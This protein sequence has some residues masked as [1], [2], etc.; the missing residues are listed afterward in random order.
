MKVLVADKLAEEGL[1]FL[2]GSG[3]NF[4]VKVGLKE[5]ELAAEVAGGG[6]EALIVRSGAKVTAKV[7]ENPGALRAIARAG[8]GVDNIDLEAATNKGILVLNTAEAS[9][10][11]TAEHA[12][13][14]LMSLARK[15]PQAHAH[16]RGGGWK[17]ND[18]QGTQLAGKTAGVVGLGRIG[19]TVAS[20]LLALEMTV[21]GFDPYFAG[22]TALDGKVKLVR[23]FDEFL[24]Q[25]DVITFHVPGGEGTKHLLSRER[26]F[27]VA[28]KS[29][30]VINDA[31]GEV[32]D[33]FALAEALKEKRIA[34]AALDV[35][36]SEPPQK[37]HP[38]FGLENVVLTPHLGASTDEAQTAVS[39]EACKA[40]VAYLS[41]GEI[42]GAVNA[43]GL[44]LDLPADERPFADLAARM[45]TLLSG[46]TE[47]AI[48]SI[49][50]RAS[51]AKAPKL[52]QTMMRLA[53]V[54]LLRPHVEAGINVINAEVI[55][56]GRG[57]DLVTVH[58]PNP[59]AG[60]V[61]DIVSIRAELQSGGTHRILGTV[62]ADG[63]PRVVRIDNFAM[64]MVPEGQMVLIV[65]KD[66][67][68]V[69]GVVGTSF[70][71]AGVNIADMVISRDFAADGSATAVMVLKVD[72]APPESLVN[73]L[74]ARPNIVKVRS[75]V[76]PPRGK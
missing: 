59:P 21:V 61:G 22:E 1:E 15:V 17:R 19:R 71:D 43:G 62:Y 4:E 14:L 11:S 68:G 50:V 40:I 16:V 69:I 63:L 46:M 75:V 36:A 7:L 2:K 25:I 70:G 31:R 44:R 54:E 74:K 27:G 13:A 23:D 65:N 60:M 66:Q 55:A 48:K 56:R 35:Y 73:R 6:Y 49:T 67:P 24:K 58:E 39:V 8:V 57:I 12:I 53:T 51:G 18:Y 29:L 5:P 3:A 38:L 30:M 9:T 47:G 10:L 26:L 33:E 45:G 28:R 72:S 37:D 32:L 34:G 20:R 42:R 64:D 76:L 41:R 52:L